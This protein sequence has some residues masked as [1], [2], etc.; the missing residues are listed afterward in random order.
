VDRENGTRYKLSDFDDFHFMSTEGYVYS[1][2][3]PG[4]SET[5][6]R[7]MLTLPPGI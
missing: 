3:S 2:N 7:E 4:A 1:A 6:L 5:I